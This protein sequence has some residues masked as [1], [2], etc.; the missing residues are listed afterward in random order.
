M[1]ESK[2]KKINHEKILISALIIFVTCQI[3]NAL[4]GIVLCSAWIIP[5]AY[6][7]I[8]RMLYPLGI[9]F[10][11]CMVDTAILSVVHKKLTR[12]YS[13][14]AAVEYWILYLPVG[15]LIKIYLEAYD[16]MWQLGLVNGIAFILSAVFV[17]LI[18]NPKKAEEITKI[19]KLNKILVGIGISIITIFLCNVF[20]PLVIEAFAAEAWNINKIDITYLWIF[21][22]CMVVLLITAIIIQ[23]LTKG[24]YYLCISV[25]SLLDVLFNVMLGYHYWKKFCADKSLEEYSFIEYLDVYMEFDIG[26]ALGVL[27]AILASGIIYK[28]ISTYQQ[29]NKVGKTSIIILSFAGAFIVPT[30]LGYPQLLSVNEK[31][32]LEYYDAEEIETL[33]CIDDTFDREDPDALDMSIV[34]EMQ[35]DGL[36]HITELNYAGQFVPD[37]VDLSAFTYLK[38]I[39]FGRTG[40]D[41]VILPEELETISAAA[42]YECYRLEEMVIPENVKEIGGIAFGECD[43]LKKVTFYNKDAKMEDNAFY[44]TEGIEEIKCYKNSAESNFS[45]EGNPKFAYWDEE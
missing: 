24:K 31:E 42:F 25:I 43:N 6:M 34:W 33:T 13:I 17:N 44:G 18:Y 39:K 1:N 38:I 28:M 29:G 4:Y 20:A 12:K 5:E 41:T 8:I 32:H 14:V 3:S 36:F 22:I 2:E 27:C 19:K 37:V 15:I 11:I 35:E 16:F 23:F 30:V 10:I 26:I 9:Y 21:I 40:M 45:Y 7:H